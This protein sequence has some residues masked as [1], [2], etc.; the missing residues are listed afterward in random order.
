[1][2]YE[3]VE[4]ITNFTIC[5]MFHNFSPYILAIEFWNTLLDLSFFA[6]SIMV[7]TILLVFRNFFWRSGLLEYWIQSNVLGHWFGCPFQRSHSHRPGTPLKSPCQEVGFICPCV[8]TNPTDLGATKQLLRTC[9]R[10]LLIPCKVT[11]SMPCSPRRFLRSR[12]TS[13][14]NGVL[15]PL[16]VPIKASSSTGDLS[17]GRS[18][19]TASGCSTSAWRWLCWSLNKCSQNHLQ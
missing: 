18:W 11:T 10:S 14:R 7:P 2:C 17:W 15:T 5:M 3:M 4:T 13:A 16:E 12:T 1:M 8:V 6:C 19:T 9:S